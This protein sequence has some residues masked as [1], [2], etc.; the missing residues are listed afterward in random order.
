V[1]FRAGRGEAAVGVEVLH[2]HLHVMLADADG[3]ADHVL[4][5]GDERGMAAG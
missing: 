4:A 1:E 3:L 2:L 5:A